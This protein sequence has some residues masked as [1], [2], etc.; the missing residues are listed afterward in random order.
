[1]IR[2]ARMED[3][4]ALL[5]VYAAARQDMARSG[6]PTQWGDG[7]PK[8]ALLEADIQAG[9]LY[10]LERE[11]TVRG[12]F[13]FIVGDDPTY[14]VIE[15]GRWLDGAPYGT[16]HRLTGNGMEKGLFSQCLAF[17]RGITPN[18]RAD[19]HHDNR[20][21]RHLLEK[22]GFTRCG[23]IHVADGSPRIAYQLSAREV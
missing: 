21:M 14:A 6:N 11:G 19:T 15:N 23:I 18:I 1:M 9:Q 4:D 20:I 3:L 10:V 13:A 22:H 7:Y 5:A 12:A 17:C 16:I 8:R 2:K